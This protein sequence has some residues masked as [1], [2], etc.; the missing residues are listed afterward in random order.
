MH[1]RVKNIKKAYS[2]LV[3]MKSKVDMVLK[4]FTFPVTNVT[5]KRSFLL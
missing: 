4:I 1:I 3:G 5:A 2:S